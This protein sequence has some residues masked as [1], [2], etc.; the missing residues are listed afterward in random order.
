M[1]SFIKTNLSW[2]LG[3]LSFSILLIILEISKFD[4]N[5]NLLSGG[6]YFKIGS[7]HNGRIGENNN[8]EITGYV[9]CPTTVTSCTIPESST[10]PNNAI[11]SSSFSTV[12]GPNG[13]NACALTAD[14]DVYYNGSITAGATLFTVKDSN[15][16]LSNI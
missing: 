11:V 4:M 2:F 14:Q 12:A 10:S 15:N 5:N 3:F 1:E 13:A 7:N 16:N 9:Q 6:K 8:G